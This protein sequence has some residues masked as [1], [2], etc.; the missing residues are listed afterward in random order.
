M[1]SQTEPVQDDAHAASDVGKLTRMGIATDLDFRH[2]TR[3]RT[4]VRGGKCDLRSYVMRVSVLKT[5]C[6]LLEGIYLYVSL[7]GNPPIFRADDHV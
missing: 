3:G 7:H 5:S 6:A 1:R 2:P 4:L